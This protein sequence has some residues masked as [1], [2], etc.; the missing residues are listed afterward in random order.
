M[1][2]ALLA[3]FEES[4]PPLKY[5][6]TELIVFYLANMLSKRGHTVFLFASGDSKTSANLIPVFPRAIRKEPYASNLKI[7]DA[8]KYIGISKLVK[9]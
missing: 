9:N 2:I 6:G 5:G 4:I 3:P 8:I 1:K 7:R